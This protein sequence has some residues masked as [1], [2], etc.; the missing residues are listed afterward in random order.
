MPRRPSASQMRA[1]TA[2]GFCPMPPEKTRVSVRQESIGDPSRSRSNSTRGL[3]AADR[4][5]RE[6]P[7]HLDPWS[8]DQKRHCSKPESPALRD[9]RSSRPVF[10]TERNREAAT[11]MVEA[12]PCI[13]AHPHEERTGRTPQDRADHRHPPQAGTRPSRSSAGRQ[14]ASGKGRRKRSCGT[15]Q[16]YRPE[17]SQGRPLNSGER[18]ERSLFMLMPRPSCKS[19]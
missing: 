15:A 19:F 7:E 6:S 12:A 10:A 13:R 9:G 3:P 5:R 14:T 18:Q 2:A 1:R 4:R 16:E 11:G 17:G 8:V